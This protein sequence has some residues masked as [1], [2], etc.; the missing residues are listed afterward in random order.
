MAAAGA[1]ITQSAAKTD[2]ES[3]R[4]LGAGPP[5]LANR[6]TATVT[7][8]AGDPPRAKYLR[9]DRVEQH[10]IDWDSEQGSIRAERNWARV[11]FER[12]GLE[13]LTTWNGPQPNGLVGACRSEN[14]A[15]GAECQ[16]PNSGAVPRVG[17][18]RTQVRRRPQPNGIVGAILLTFFLR[19]SFAEGADAGW[20]VGH[21]LLVQLAGVGVTVLYAAIVT[22]VLAFLVQKTVGLRVS[23]EAEMAGLDHSAHGEHG[24]G[25]LNP[26]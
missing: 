14:L 1:F 2:I 11:A 15:V 5:H 13:Q 19:A 22:L 20:T 9:S 25:L 16:M 17:G 26:T 21:Q 3:G 10:L 8:V 18:E 12:E 7:P 4:P 6:L 23:D 24:Y